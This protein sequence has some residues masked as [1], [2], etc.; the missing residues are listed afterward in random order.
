[1]IEIGRKSTSKNLDL[2]LGLD[3]STDQGRDLVHAPKGNL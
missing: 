2:V 3:L 1:M